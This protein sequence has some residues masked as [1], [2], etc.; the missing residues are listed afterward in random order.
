MN[1]P[2]KG[3]I[4]V[5]LTPFLEN[6]EIDYDGLTELTEFYL[7]SGATG[8]FA[9]CLS[10]EMFELTPQERI[11]VTQH[12]VK[13]ASDGVPVVTTGTFGSAVEKQADF[14]DQIYQTG[15]QAVI[16]ITSSLANEDEPDE[17]F[18]E[19]IF[20]LL[21][22]T[23]K[24]PLGFYECPVPYKRVLSP[25]QLKLFIPTGRITYHKDTCLNIEQ[26]R[27]KVAVGKGYAFGLYDAYLVHAVESLKAGSAGLSCIQGNFF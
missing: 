16:M 13:V 22:R 4:P 3:F 15:V 9:N 19:R 2:G 18:N 20:E 12:V 8:L 1:Y 26:V 10:S 25:Q 23:G 5:M 24:I 21:H 11:K 17:V 27:A 14:I 7:A 6:G